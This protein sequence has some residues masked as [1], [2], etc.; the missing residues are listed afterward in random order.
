M[1]TRENDNVDGT[2]REVSAM[3][4]RWP[5]PSPVA[6]RE[7]LYDLA[8][9]LD[10][11]LPRDGRDGIEI[12]DAG[13][14]TGHRLVACAK[15]FPHAR[16]TGIDI[17]DASIDIA[18]QLAARHGVTNV[19]FLR[20]DLLDPDLDGTFHVITAS[21][22]IHH[23]ERPAAAVT[24]L[25]EHLT[26][27]GLI[28]IWLYHP[29]GERQRLQQRELLHEGMALIEELGLSLD[30]RRYGSSAAQA[31]QGDLQ[32][33]SVDADAFMHPIVSAYRFEE[34]LRLFADARID[35]W[36]VNGLNTAAE[37][38]LLDLEDVADEYVRPLCVSID[39]LLDRDSLV[40]RYR[41]LRKRD[42]L[43]IIELLTQPTGFT[44][45]GGRGASLGS[46]DTR[47]RGNCVWTR[48]DAA[49]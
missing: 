15:R 30:Q 14:G 38:K 37:S 28:S 5:Y 34:A 31:G 41:R 44:V 3:Y 48:G 10:M 42:R 29:F 24:N 18:R 21:G 4:S 43:T 33:R 20:Q 9:M 8:S 36:S 7:L 16:F 25:C 46:L 39:A 13:C 45:L 6:G 47:A 35:W 40:A 2:W 27:H 12:L 23:T 49:G 22:V 17:T 26:D 32:Q 19:R 1:G 11:V